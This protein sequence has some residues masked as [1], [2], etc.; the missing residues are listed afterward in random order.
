[1][2][3]PATFHAPDFTTLHGRELAALLNGQRDPL[4]SH[5]LLLI[6]THSDFKTGWFL[7][8]YA[9][10]QEL[11]TPPAPER[12]PRRNGPTLKEIRSA[13]DRLI[14]S[15]V[16]WRDASNLHNKQLRLRVWPRDVKSASEA[17]TGSYQGRAE[18]ARYQA[19]M[20]V[21]S[22]SKAETGQRTG[23]GYQ[24][25]NSISPTPCGQPTYPQS[26]TAKDTAMKKISDLLAS[27]NRPPKGG[28]AR[29]AAR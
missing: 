4:C 28:E 11:S 5:L 18:K 2:S 13:I 23:Q 7:G 17:L 29:G 12:G 14:A 19:F 6:V 1:M 24:Q 15:G 22:P 9:R 27:V 20:R 8:S 10:L 3:L 25:L 16:L 26:S 21:S